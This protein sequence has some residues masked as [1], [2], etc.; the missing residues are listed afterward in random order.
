[1]ARA[2]A[3]PHGEQDKLI[4]VS[5]AILLRDWLKA[6]GTDHRLV[7]YPDHGHFLPRA[8]VRERTLGFLKEIAAPACPTTGDP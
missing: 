6:G 3:Y 2:N 7:L 1:M 5:Q 8:N 4:P